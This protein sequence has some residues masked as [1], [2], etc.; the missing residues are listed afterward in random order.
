VT[1][2]EDHTVSG[3]TPP[4]PD[5]IGI[6]YDEFA[7]FYALINSD[8]SFHIGMWSGTAAHEP[9]SVHELAD[10]A[11]VRVV[12]HCIETLGLTETDHLLDIGCGA[13]APAIQIARHSG[14][15]ATGINVS[16]GQLAEAT[17]R[18]DAAG[19]ADRVTFQ[20]GNAME[21]DFADES[22][23]AALAID[24]FPHLSDRQQAFN[25]A[26]R[27]LKPGGTLLLSEFTLRG[28]PPEEQFSAYLQTFQ[29]MPPIAPETSIGLA[30]N[31]G[32]ELVRAERMT[33]DV[34]LSTEVMFFLYHD[35]HDAITERYGPEAVA[36]LDYVMPL[37]RAYMRDHLGYYYFLLQKPA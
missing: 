8:I 21:L 22:F 11:Q 25:E 9:A 29:A 19:I 23:D 12:E 33:K 10:R 35:R 36:E 5:D 37:I 2:T 20:Y 28:T 1:A 17:Q 30:A 13:G 14:G 6:N 3:F 31:A 32:F 34:A 26:F 27:V 15:R 16:K 7:D 4:N 24:L 18:A